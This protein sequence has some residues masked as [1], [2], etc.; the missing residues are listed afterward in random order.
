[1]LMMCVLTVYEWKTLCKLFLLIVCITVTYSPVIVRICVF[2][3]VAPSIRVIGLE[4]HHRG[5]PLLWLVG[6]GV[7]KRGRVWCILAIS[8][9]PS[10][11]D[12]QYPLNALGCNCQCI[13][14]CVSGSVHIRV[15]SSPPCTKCLMCFPCRR[16]SQE[17]SRMLLQV[18]SQSQ[19]CCWA[20]H[21]CRG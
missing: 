3:R 17:A 7:I 20:T 8:P 9:L 2:S 1:M 10:W 16:R 4:L 15:H 12:K 13:T 21:L 18:G 5:N 14:T 11:E 6:F 19:P